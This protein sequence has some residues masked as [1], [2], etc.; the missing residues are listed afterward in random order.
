M[1]IAEKLAILADAAKYDASCASSGAIRKGRLDALGSADESGICHS[2]TPDRRCVS[3][4]RILLTNQCVWDCGFCV[5]RA[6][7]DIPRARFTPEEVVEL[8]LD[9][10]RR[11]YIEGLFLSSG[12]L[13]DP[14]TT[15][16]QMVR[17]A[18]L[19]RDVHRF[20]GYVHLSSSPAY[21]PR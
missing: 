1:G 6:S 10:Y 8:T 13:R 14:D 17:V 11:N 5:N 21:P 9:F 12:I 15:V 19:L 2:Y 20:N 3:L 7:N 16:E 18:R 4:L